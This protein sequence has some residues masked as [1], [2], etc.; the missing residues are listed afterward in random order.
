M[1]CPKCGT[2]LPDGASFCSVC[3]TQLGQQMYQQAQPG[4]YQQPQPGMQQP[5]PGMYQQPQPGMYQQPQPGMYQPGY[6]P[7]PKMIRVPKY[8]K[9]SMCR[10]VGASLITICSILPAWFGA[11]Y[12]SGMYQ[13]VGFF[14]TGGGILALWGVLFLLAG[15]AL[16]FF[17]IDS[18]PIRNAQGAFHALPYAR[19]YIPAFCV[20]NF[21]LGTFAHSGGSASVGWGWWL[22]LLGILL[23]FV[24][25]I[26]DLVKGR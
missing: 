8:V 10:V 17:E 1:N 20:L 9:P 4:M 23:T 19:F 11:Y 24:S 21:I 12:G 5:Q 7:R 6:M 14:A 26:V 2:M 22:T 25:P 15:L 16:L 18:P 13:G 3:G